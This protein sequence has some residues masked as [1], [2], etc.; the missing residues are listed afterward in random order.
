MALK[1]GEKKQII[2]I[3]GQYMDRQFTEIEMALKHL[4]LY[5]VLFII[6]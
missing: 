1:N 5:S 3:L 2:K 4:K 6:R